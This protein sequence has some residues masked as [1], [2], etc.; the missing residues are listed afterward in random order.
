LTGS[1]PHHD[2]DPFGSTTSSVGYFPNPQVGST[3]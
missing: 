2:I 1:R 3:N